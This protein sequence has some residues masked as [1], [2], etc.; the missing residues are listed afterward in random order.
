MNTKE[1]RLI[2]LYIKRLIV[3]VR[4]INIEEYLD[5]L[6]S[7]KIVEQQKLHASLHNR[8]AEV[9]MEISNLQGKLNVLR[10]KLEKLNSEV[11]DLEK[12]L[13]PKTVS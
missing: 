10:P 4:I 13:K 9:L 8:H 3:D 11:K 5:Y 6:E 7:E 12:F 2:W 1:F